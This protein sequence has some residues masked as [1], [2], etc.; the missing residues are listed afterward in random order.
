MTILLGPLHKTVFHDL[1]GMMDFIKAYG[2]NGNPEA[3][4]LSAHNAAKDIGYYRK[5]AQNLGA[6]TISACA[7]EALTT[8]VEQGIGD[9]LAPQMVDFFTKR[10]SD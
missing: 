4:A 8:A 5:M 3:L 1:F 2:I 9:N 10:F 7:N 6:N